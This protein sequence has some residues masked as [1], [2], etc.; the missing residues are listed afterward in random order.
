MQ[1]LPHRYSA[2]HLKN[3]KPKGKQRTLRTTKTIKKRL[4]V[5]KTK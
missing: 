5:R 2:V 1:I 3:K 4:I